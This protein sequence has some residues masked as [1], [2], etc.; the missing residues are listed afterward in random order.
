[1][2]FSI[3]QILLLV[4]MATSEENRFFCYRDRMERGIEGEASVGDLIVYYL[5]HTTKPFALQEFEVEL[6]PM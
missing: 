4:Q 2:L 6:E 1:M 5:A 3:D